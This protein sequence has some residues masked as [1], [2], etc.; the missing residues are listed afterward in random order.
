MT[1]LAVG[2]P[3]ASIA[4]PCEKE[5]VGCAPVGEWQFELAV[6]YGEHVNPIRGRDN[7]PIVLLPSLSYY[8]E[9]F[10]FE[11]DTVGFTLVDAS[12]HQLNLVAMP[13]H[14]QIYFEDFGLGNISLEDGS[15]GSPSLGLEDSSSIGFGD[16]EN[17]LDEEYDGSEE[18]IESPELESLLEVSPD[19]EFLPIET[20]SVTYDLRKRKIAGLA[21][22][23]Y[24]WSGDR[25][26]WGVQWLNDFT[27]RHE[28]SEIRLAMSYDMPLDNQGR[29]NFGLGAKWRSQEIQ[30]YYFGIDAS[31]VSDSRKV[32]EAGAGLSPFV[33]I[34]WQKAI[35]KRWRIKTSFRYAWLND[36]ISDSPLVDSDSI[37]SVF[38]GGVYHF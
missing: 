2:L 30:D 8:G 31:E 21:G 26:H 18:S 3:I 25:I 38:V 17:A 19:E 6:G 7:I 10:F 36:E 28:G 4:D 12:Q 32:Y 29:L 1:S 13:G 22:I 5:G 23:E 24:G 37:I 15:F 34:Q 27:G 33:K 35:N 9:R 16:T 11:T 14:D 20:E